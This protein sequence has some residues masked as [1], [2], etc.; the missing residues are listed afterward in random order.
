[1]YAIS[2]AKG[3]AS[4]H[5]VAVGTSDH[6]VCLCDLRTGNSA[7]HL[8]G[9]RDSVFATQWRPGNEYHLVTGSAD[10][11]LRLWDIR[12][13]GSLV[14]FN[15]NQTEFRVRTDEMTQQ[16]K[17]KRVHIPYSIPTSIRS[18]DGFITAVHWTP[19][20]RFVLSSGTDNKMRL[21]DADKEINTL[22]H[23]DG[24]RNGQL[25]GSQIAVSSNGQL[26]YHPTGQ[27]ILVFE[28]HTG[29]LI[30][31]LRGHYSKVNTCVFHSFLPELYSGGNDSQ[32]IL[33]TSLLDEGVEKEDNEEVLWSS[34]SGDDEDGIDD[35]T[36]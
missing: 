17:S 12:R 23:Y 3:A 5:L 28:I 22:V 21:W 15:Q 16:K 4:H 7:H 9:H 34:S 11:T 25:K 6:K 27:V 2:M 24:V 10:G 31:I 30:N 26:V 14:I 35:L 13:G 32:I 33:W 1:V 19:D 18:H 20:G 29:K 36:I 8:F